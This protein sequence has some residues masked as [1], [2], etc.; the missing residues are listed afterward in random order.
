MCTHTSGHAHNCKCKQFSHINCTYRQQKY[1]VD[2]N[3][4]QLQCT[5]TIQAPNST[6]NK[7]DSNV[8]TLFYW[9]INFLFVLVE[10]YLMIY[11]SCKLCV[12]R[13]ILHV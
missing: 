10:T 1:T 11:S 7:M 12:C 4:K 3:G 6:Q 13:H 5:D 2:K 9:S 8:K